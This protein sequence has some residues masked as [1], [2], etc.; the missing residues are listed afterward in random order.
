[1]TRDKPCGP[2]L[3]QPAN[4]VNCRPDRS[5]ETNQAWAWW[6]SKLAVLWVLDTYYPSGKN[7]NKRRYVSSMIMR[8]VIRLE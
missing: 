2:R 6:I 4:G 8:P 5:G 7:V 1:M 3:G